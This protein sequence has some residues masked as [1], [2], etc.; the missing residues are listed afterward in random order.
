MRVIGV[1]VSAWPQLGP[2]GMRRVPVRR[3][4]ARLGDNANP[5]SS[6]AIS[7]PPVSTSAAGTGPTAPLATGSSLAAGSLA[8]ALSGQAQPDLAV[9]LDNATA[10]LVRDYAALHPDDF[11][12]WLATYAD[13]I[14]L[15]DNMFFQAVANPPSGGYQLSPGMVVSLGSTAYKL[16]Q[17]LNGVAVGRYGDLFGVSASLAG[18]IP[19]VSPDLVHTLQGLTLAYRAFSG[20]AQVASIAAANPG[21]AL[22]DL[23]A[24]MGAYP[25]LA[26]ASGTQLLSGALMVVGLAVDIGFTIAGNAPD[27]QKAVDVA[28]DAASIAVLFIPVV[29]IIIAVVIQIVKLIVD[30]FGEDLFGGG[31]SHDERE[32]LEAAA[33]SEHLAP[34]YPAL[35][36]AYTPRELWAV[37]V[38]WGSGYCGGHQVVAIGVN[39]ILKAGDTLRVGGQLMTMPPDAQNPHYDATYGGTLLGFGDNEQVGGCYWLRS[40]PFAAIT[41]DEQAWALGR[42]AAQNGVHAGA[43]VGISEDKKAQFNMPT[44]QVIEARTAPMGRLLAAGY[45]LDQLDWIVAEYRAQPALK[46]LATTFG[47]L[48]WQQMLGD[49]L[50]GEWQSFTANVSHGTLTDFAR[51]NG[52]ATMSAFRAAA[53]ASHQRYA[54]R[55]TAVRARSATL[56]KWFIP[57]THT[58]AQAAYEYQQSQLSTP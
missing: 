49:L 33:Y 53:L 7:T 57:I 24:S 41:N 32:L 50:A 6:G 31:L 1:R 15:R 34:M 39:L 42:Y 46:V 2:T 3:L 40:G 27:M 52:Y 18:Q 35:A 45:S 17:A 8:T 19:G 11:Q 22:L 51:R 29:G 56:A 44:E 48:G 28:L 16:V 23:T 10:L 30:I 20:A 54:D 58:A 4:R 38:A 37:I 12:A 14:Q 25:G 36:A 55:L 9:V 13:R 5:E 47:W 21:T 26:A 43:Q